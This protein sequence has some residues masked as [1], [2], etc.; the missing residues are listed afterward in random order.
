MGKTKIADL[1]PAKLQGAIEGY[2]ILNTN[3]P[4]R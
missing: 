3:L 1:P 2:T 4:P